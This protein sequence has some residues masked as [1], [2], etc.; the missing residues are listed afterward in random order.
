MDE[1]SKKSK[2]IKEKLA[3][4]DANTAKSDFIRHFVFYLAIIVGLFIIAYILSIL[5]SFLSKNVKSSSYLNV[6]SSIQ[7]SNYS[8]LSECDSPITK[9]SVKYNVRYDWYVYGT[10]SSLIEIGYIDYKTERKESHASGIGYVRKITYFM[11]LSQFY[12]ISSNNSSNNSNTSTADFEQT[13][14][15]IT[16][17]YNY[18]SNFNCLNASYIFSVQ[19]KEYPQ[20]A[21]CMPAD[22]PTRICME[23]LIDLNRTSNMNT[24]AGSF[25]VKEYLLRSYEQPTNYPSQSTSVSETKIAISDLPFPITISSEG[26]ELRLSS[27]EKIE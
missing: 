27:Y 25:N 5:P 11:N 22:I 17:L 15:E 9:D 14:S 20:S 2:K 3:K 26:M 13:V 7:Q 1:K 4:E 18:D 8:Y 24:E 12:E 19:G 16:M 21:D 10:N 23:S 6:S